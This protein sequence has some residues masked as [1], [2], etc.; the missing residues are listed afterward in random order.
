[1]AD[2]AGLR[3]RTDLAVLTGCD[4]G[5][6]NAT[7]G[8]DVVGLTRSLL[9]SGVDRTVV[10]LWPVDDSIAP[11]MMQHFYAAMAE[12]Q[13][14]AF[15]LAE[16][17]RRLYQMSTEELQTAYSGLGGDSSSNRRRGG[18]LSPE[19]VDDEELP[20]TLVGDAERYWAPFVLVG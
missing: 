7:L 2:I 19:L 11:V 8:G 20:P 14:P 16:A 12:R 4:T 18:E 1:M 6:G 17:Q 15:A 9:R 3:F 10:S 13:P 5:R